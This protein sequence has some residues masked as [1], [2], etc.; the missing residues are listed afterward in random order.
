M[1]KSLK[2]SAA[3]MTTFNELMSTITSSLD[4]LNRIKEKNVNIA[5]G[6]CKDS[7]NV[8]YLTAKDV[9]SFVDN[10]GKIVTRPGILC[11][12][13]DCEMFM[14]TSVRKALEANGCTPFETSAGDFVTALDLS[15]K[16]CT[17]TDL[18]N[19]WKHEPLAHTTVR[20]SQEMKERLNDKRFV[21]AKKALVDE[22]FVANM[23]NIVKALPDVVAKT[24]H[25]G[26]PANILMVLA[27]EYI[28]FAASCFLMTIGDMMDYAVPA[29]TYSTN[30][31]KAVM[32][33]CLLKSAEMEVNRTLPFACDLKNIVLTAYPPEFKDIKAALDYIENDSRSPIAYLMTKYSP[34]V[35]DTKD[36]V[37]YDQIVSKLFSHQPAYSQPFVSDNSLLGKI[38][39]GN[40]YL[41]GNYRID[42]NG[43]PHMDSIV[44]TLGMIDRLY[45][46]RDL[47]DN[48]S[49]VKHMR[50][51]H[52]CIISACEDY[53]FSGE[54]NLEYF[55][56]IVCAFADIYTKTMLK[57]Y[58][59]NTKILDF[60]ATEKVPDT[61]VPAYMY[62]E[63]F[64]M[65]A[66][67]APGA[68]AAPAAPPAP[69]GTNAAT[70]PAAPAATQQPAAQQQQTTTPAAPAKNDTNAK[71]T[72]TTKDGNKEPGTL[73]KIG[74]AIMKAITAFLNWVI[75][76][77]A[78]FGLNF[79][80]NH[81][82]QLDYLKKNDKINKQIGEAMATADGTPES[83]I[84]NINNFPQFNIPLEEIKS[85][86]TVAVFKKWL[87]STEVIDKNAIKQELYPAGLDKAKLATCNN[88]S[89]EVDL[90]SNY[91]LYKQSEPKT[92]TGKCTKE[93]WEEIIKNIQE[94][95]EAVDQATNKV[96]SDLKGVLNNLQSTVRANMSVTEKPAEQLTE[97]DKKKQAMCD[98]AKAL[99]EIA[100]EVSR[101]YFTT[102]INAIADRF[103]KENWKAYSDI[104]AVW[105][106]RVKNGGQE[107]PAPE[108]KPAEQTPPADQTT[109][110][111]T[112][113]A[114]NP[115]AA[116]PAPGTP[117]PTGT[118]AGAAAAA[119]ATT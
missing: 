22:H 85:I 106:Q 52:Q 3:F 86:D 28:L 5:Y 27:E 50:I 92:V 93:L 71:T 44:H 111:A 26:T 43:T 84:V 103:W 70:T 30:K 94:C 38:A 108:Q 73:K 66:D 65:E 39:Y 14:V 90:L 19:A 12:V 54:D 13:A 17:L 16:K 64:V 60:G 11:T 31:E 48:A 45:N 33:C 69:A 115:G 116:N 95:P 36:I 113:A 53:S 107:T 110:N 49:L 114:P 112:P 88:E 76:I 25:C 35:T 79:N 40:S 105:N 97:D 83:F 29:A 56:D 41:N 91:I 7:F 51:M 118:L 62:M 42:T 18:V 82:K 21:D 80:K 24:I 119:A 6:V 9:S 63:S 72:V 15:S 68:G 96:V 89:A 98:R 81:K 61:M 109:A 32:E 23:K 34:K 100:Q 104:I 101:I 8:R 102:T 1:N 74:E 55:R 58:N 99:L 59:N 67:A 47:E 2:Y 117:T 78:K 57:L 20:D 37:C 87:D 75:N 10:L 46:S 4:T 77:A